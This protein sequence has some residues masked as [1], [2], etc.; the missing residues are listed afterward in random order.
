MARTDVAAVVLV[1]LCAS[2]ACASQTP[3][4]R[5]SV[6]S[7]AYEAARFEPS[8]DKRNSV[9]TVG[10]VNLVLNGPDDI[11]KPSAWEG[12]LQV[13]HSDSGRSCEA[14]PSLITQVYVDTPRSVALVV[15]YSGSTTFLDFIQLDTCGAKW[16]RVEGFTERVVV[17]GDRVSIHPGCEGDGARALCTAGRVLQVHADKAPVILDGESRA[18]TI[19]VLGVD[20]TGQQRVENPKTPKARVVQ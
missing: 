10:S 5:V 9:T 18:L 19:S 6:A 15:S 2:G 7:Y 3:D 8:A 4:D 14:A 17:N 1:V 20:F 11:E 16:P 13:R 12:P